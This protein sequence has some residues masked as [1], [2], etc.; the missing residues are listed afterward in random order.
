M[1]CVL[2]TKHFTYI[3]LFILR[4]V[5]DGYWY[6]LPSLQMRNGGLER[7]SR[8]LGMKTGLNSRRL[9]LGQQSHL[10]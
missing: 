10:W 4:T 2:Q 7:E 8:R 6:H 1:K 9:I 5:Q 3:I